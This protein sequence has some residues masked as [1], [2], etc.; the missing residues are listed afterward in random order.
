[1]LDN[2]GR[3]RAAGARGELF[4]LAEPGASHLGAAAAD[5]GVEQVEGGHPA[6][7]RSADLLDVVQRDRQLGGGA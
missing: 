6:Q 5:G 2:R 4:Q 3:G 7:R 1:V